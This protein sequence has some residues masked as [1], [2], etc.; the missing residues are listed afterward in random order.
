MSKFEIRKKLINYAV[1]QIKTQLTAMRSIIF[2]NLIVPYLVKK[3]LAFYT[4][5]ELLRDHKCPR[6]ISYPESDV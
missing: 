4:T 5:S 6:L 3:F 2:E 1:C